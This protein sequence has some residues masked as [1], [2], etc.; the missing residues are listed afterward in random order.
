MNDIL[1]FS[2]HRKPGEIA[3]RVQDPPPQVA[4]LALEALQHT[5][6]WL[7]VRGDSIEICGY[8]YWVSG[9]QASPPALVLHLQ[10]E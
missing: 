3:V 2:V 6:D 7:T 9:W 4:Y 5:R 1:T 10:A 8:T